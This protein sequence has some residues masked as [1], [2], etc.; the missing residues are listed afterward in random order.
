[1]AFVE[2][3]QLEAELLARLEAGSLELTKAL[4]ERDITRITALNGRIETDRAAHQAA[5]KKRQAMQKRGFG[6]MSLRQVVAYAPRQLSL[7]ARGYCSELTYRAISLGI[8]TQ[9]NKH[10]I[11]AG[12]DRLLKIVMVLQRATADQPKTYKR[13]GFIAPPDNSLLV[14]SKA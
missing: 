4:V 3:L 13:R 14:S 2:A 5:S 11:L 9:N 12:M 1:M 8:T 7:R 10:L 6:E